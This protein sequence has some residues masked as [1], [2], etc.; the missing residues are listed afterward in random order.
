MS[1]T[2]VLMD[3]L[4]SFL[5]DS[6]RPASAGQQPG[7]A[8]AHWRAPDG[9]PPDGDPPD[10]D[11]P[12]L[13]QSELGRSQ[14]KSQIRYLMSRLVP[15]LPDS[16]LKKLTQSSSKGFSRDDVDAI[17]SFQREVEQ[18]PTVQRG[19][20]ELGMKSLMEWQLDRD[21]LMKTRSPYTHPM[22]RPLFFFP[23]LSARMR[24]DTA[25]FD[26]VPRLEAA[27]PVIKEELLRVLD[28]HQA[29]QPYV[30]ADKQ[31]TERWLVN[32]D[33]GVVFGN[34]RSAPSMWN[35][36]YL[37]MGGPVIENTALCP[38]TIKVL[39]SIPRFNRRSPNVFSALHP[40]AHIAPHH[41]PRNG[42]LRV[43]LPV[44]TPERCFLNVGSE[45]FEW[46]DGKVEIFDDSFSHQA[47][48]LSDRTRIVLHFDIYHPGWTDEEVERLDEIDRYF[49]DTTIMAIF[50]EVRDKTKD[51]LDG[52]DWMVR[53]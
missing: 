30:P 23:G 33:N 46:Q 3:R 6:L 32:S 45:L 25:E 8:G 51:L 13:F 42:V 31:G 53:G 52:K 19:M 7:R 21:R 18:L 48:N 27:H 12:F 36:M 16:V 9:D 40:G 49:D 37:Y 26:W 43:H 10:D 38:E 5:P 2:R 28:Q 22:M 17:F 15:M 20:R 41:G 39:E 29:F 11:V 1:E 34:D 14:R 35:V 4:L 24:Y 44:L 50:H 47:W